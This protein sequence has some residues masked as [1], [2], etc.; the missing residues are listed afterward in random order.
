[1]K[2]LETVTSLGAMDIT[3][4]S[5]APATSR[6]GNGVTARRWARLLR[7][8]GYR[9][10]IAQ[11][12]GGE[13]CD[14]L[15]ALHARKSHA[16]IARFHLAHPERPL[17]VCLTGTDLYG[18]LG[19]DALAQQSIEWATRLITLQPA[20]ADELPP[21]LRAKV[22]VIYQSCEPPPGQFTHRRDVF[23]VCV[24]GHLRAVKDPF[25]TAEAARL[26]PLESRIRVLHL[27]GIID[28]EM[29]RRAREV[30]AANPRYRWLGELPRWRALRVL[31]RCRLLSLTSVMEGGAN[32]VTEAIACG[33][34]VVSSRIPGS[35]GLLGADYSGYFPRG[36]TA[37]LAA[38]LRRAETDAAF[39]ADLE[40]RCE[41]LRWL[42]DPAEERR[43]W[44]ALID[45]LF[46]ARNR[47]RA[48]AGVSPLG[49]RPL[50]AAKEVRAAA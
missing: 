25:R 19:S 23:D 3:L 10:S 48:R 17:V 42:T 33:V 26:L 29:Q 14:V 31:S 28:A 15:V 4:V 39:Y 37:A 38:L 35:I 2:A 44:A 49:T 27:G 20:G 5:P 12:Y 11:D 40:R 41:R 21:H 1:M 30:M 16:S 43:R 50:P 45:E 9:V 34:P 6:K 24:M 36:D 22:R 18:D 8:L 13:A 32:V 46:E 47:R 7:E